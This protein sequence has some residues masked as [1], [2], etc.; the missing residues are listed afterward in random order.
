MIVATSRFVVANGLEGAVRD[1]FRARPHRVDDA[2]GFVKMEVLVP[3]DDPREFWLM[4]WW[5]DLPSYEAW[6]GGHTY[7][8]SHGGIPKGLK[9][10][11]QETVLRTFDRICG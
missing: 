7:K 8:D 5:T 1:A 4:T 9:L 10:V 3:Q 6:H 2:P 11:P